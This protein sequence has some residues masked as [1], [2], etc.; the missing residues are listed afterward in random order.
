MCGGL[1]HPSSGRQESNWNLTFR[2]LTPS[3]TGTDMNSSGWQIVCIRLVPGWSLWLRLGFKHTP[4]TFHRK[5]SFRVHYCSRSRQSVDDANC[6]DC[7]LFHLILTCACSVPPSFVCTQQQCPHLTGGGLTD[8]A[9]EEAQ[10]VAA[11]DLFR[12]T[13]CLSS[14]K[15]RKTSKW[16]NSKLISLSACVTIFAVDET[17]RNS[18]HLNCLCG[19]VFVHR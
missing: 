16:Y 5:V 2:A 3:L 13:L 14:L 7:R 10:T 17:K 9:W 18:L 4:L 12:Q 1:G 6:H 19:G 15:R 11:L 8:A